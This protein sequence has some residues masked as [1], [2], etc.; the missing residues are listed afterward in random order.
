[1]LEDF[2]CGSL[3][4]SSRAGVC[5]FVGMYACP[6]VQAFWSLWLER[7]GLLGRANIHSMLR[8]SGRTMVP[9]SDRS[10][11]PAT[12]HVR[13]RKPLQKISSQG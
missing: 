10:A 8:N 5:V 7:L 12:C 6:F 4:K 1:M 13:S 9:N 3:E 11:A 2:L